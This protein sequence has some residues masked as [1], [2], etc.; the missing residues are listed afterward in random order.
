MTRFLNDVSRNKKNQ[1][2]EQDSQNRLKSPMPK[3]EIH[4]TVTVTIRQKVYSSDNTRKTP[5]EQ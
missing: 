1:R 4:F 2:A 5:M 3:G